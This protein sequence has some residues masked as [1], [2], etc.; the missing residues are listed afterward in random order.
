MKIITSIFSFIL[1]LNVVIANTQPQSCDL[2]NWPKG[3]SPLEIGTRIA[4]K[5]LRTPHSLYGNTHPKTP[6]TQITYP[7]ICFDKVESEGLF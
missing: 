5:F 6:P 3:K 7:D 2:K 4:E 1:L